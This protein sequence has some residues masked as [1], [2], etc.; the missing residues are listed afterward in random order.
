MKVDMHARHQDI[1]NSPRPTA[2]DVGMNGDYKPHRGKD[3]S[4]NHKLSRS[5]TVDRLVS[6]FEGHGHEN[7]HD[8]EHSG[9]LSAHKVRH[10]DKHEAGMEANLTDHRSK[11]H[12]IR[13]S[14]F[15]DPLASLFGES[16]RGAQ[17]VTTDEHENIKVRHHDKHGAG[18]VDADADMKTSHGGQGKHG[19]KENANADGSKQMS[20][21]LDPPEASGADQHRN[22]HGAG[23]NHHAGARRSRRDL[24][25]MF[26]SKSPGPDAGLADAS[27]KNTSAHLVQTPGQDKTIID[28]DA[29]KADMKLNMPT[30]GPGVGEEKIQNQGQNIGG[31]LANGQNGLGPSD[32]N[33]NIVKQMEGEVNGDGKDADGAGNDISEEMGVGPSDDPVKQTEGELSGDGTETQSM[34]NDISKG[35][36]AFKQ[37]GTEV[38]RTDDPCRL[39]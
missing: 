22:P 30:S 35:A 33:G 21:L 12:K 31:G 10:D 16:D 23:K 34:G 7:K 28:V 17:G 27:S 25:T 15:K 5:G 18:K 14:G 3:K 4:K 29:G 2:M 20:T 38:S 19:H 37:P 11:T 32:Q 39:A 13:R 8:G 24:V 6:L 26:P 9:K 1:P 36:A